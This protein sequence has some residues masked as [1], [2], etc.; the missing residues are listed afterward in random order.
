MLALYENSSTLKL[1]ATA[2][3]RFG[4]VLE[5][6]GP[7]SPPDSQ[8]LPTKGW[9]IIKPSGIPRAIEDTLIF[10]GNHLEGTQQ[11]ENWPGKICPPDQ[12]WQSCKQYPMEFFNGRNLK[13]SLN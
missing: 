7:E 5:E 13:M 9:K 3:P 2:F 4:P 11:L 6:I 8:D 12:L 1:H 10:F